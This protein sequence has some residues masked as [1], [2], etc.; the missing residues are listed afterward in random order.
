MEEYS[1]NRFHY[2]SKEFDEFGAMM[3]AALVEEKLLESGHFLGTIN[4]VQT[5]HVIVSNI[6]INRKVLQIGSAP[7]GYIS[8]VI[9]DPLVFYSWRKHEMKKGMIGVLWDKEHQSVSG[10]GIKGLPISIEE[11]FFIQLCRIKGY[12]ELVDLLR[13]SET[14]YLLENDLAK[15]SQLTKFITQN[16][17]LPNNT[18]YQ[19]IEEKL[20]DLL[21]KGISK[22]FTKKTDIDIT[23]PKFVGVIDYIHDNLCNIS[24]VRQICENTQVP[25]RTVQ[26]L[27]NKK[28]NISPK[29]YLN[30]LRLNEVRKEL[31]KDSNSS[32]VFE[33]ASEYNFWHMG[34]F[35]KDYKNLFGELPSD[36]LRG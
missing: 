32:R 15:I 23:H 1:I 25:E 17:D 8:F 13:K 2:S 19:L 28:Y 34:Q 12:P 16:K 7:P 18:I 4:T 21:I 24:S 20:L 5:S 22:T 33:I 30:N 26:R 29:I 14:L 10:S 3:R 36:T 6:N 11:K 31:K 9:C 27:I 35:S